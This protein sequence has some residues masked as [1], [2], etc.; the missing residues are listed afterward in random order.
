MKS[1]K[2]KIKIV[3]QVKVADNEEPGFPPQ[4]PKK[5]NP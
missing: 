3:K 4:K 5:K 2:S 1:K